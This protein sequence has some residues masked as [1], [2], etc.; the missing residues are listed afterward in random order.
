MILGVKKIFII[1]SV[2]KKIGL[3]NEQECEDD[4]TKKAG[5]V[6]RLQKKSEQIGC[7]L[8]NLQFHDAQQ[9]RMR[10][11]GMKN[12]NSD[13]RLSSRPE[14]SHHRQSYTPILLEKAPSPEPLT[15]PN[16]SNN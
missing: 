1:N 9:L 6:S 12:S 4:L 14:R 16:Q 8:S 3:G 15:D 7:L 5:L 11:A 10:N 2:I 13:T